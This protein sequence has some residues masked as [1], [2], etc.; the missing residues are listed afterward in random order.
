[1]LE[2]VGV[3]DILAFERGDEV[4]PVGAASTAVEGGLVDPEAGLPP[5]V[6]VADRLGCGLEL[7]VGAILMPAALATAVF[8][9]GSADL[10]AV[11]VLVAL[12]RSD[13]DTWW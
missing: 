7:D 1:M 8:G 12:V 2:A 11:A 6:E 13:L 10:E 5:D 9:Q 4:L 3:R